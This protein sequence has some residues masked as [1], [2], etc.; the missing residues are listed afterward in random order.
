MSWITL[1]DLASGMTHQQFR[2]KVVVACEKY[3][4]GRE[5]VLCGVF[6]LYPSFVA[7]I[8][9]AEEIHFYV[10]CNDK[11]KY[12]DY[13]EKAISGQRCNI[14]CISYEKNYFKLSS[15]GETA[16]LKFKKIIMEGKFPSEL[17]FFMV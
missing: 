4:C 1:R 3:C 5:Q 10:L 2:V 13:I 11:L 16:V 17:T 15:S 6:A 12:S 8:H 14:S 9:H 7:G